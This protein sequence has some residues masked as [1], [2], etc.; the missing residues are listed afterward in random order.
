[1][2]FVW[3]TSVYTNNIT[4][5]TSQNWN[6]PCVGYRSSWDMRWQQS[7]CVD[8][9]QLIDY[10]MHQFINKL[11]A[12][13]VETPYSLYIYIKAIQTLLSLKIEVYIRCILPGVNQWRVTTSCVQL[14]QKH[15]SSLDLCE[16]RLVRTCQSYVH[17][18]VR[19]LLYCVSPRQYWEAHI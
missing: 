11:T 4:I 8:R 7:S 13:C 16:S 17:N 5:T 18:T 14:S 6:L 10:S 15:A 2:V 12:C 1:M 19:S 9:H 3:F